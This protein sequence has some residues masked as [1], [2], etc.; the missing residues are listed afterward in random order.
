MQALLEF[1]PLVAFVVAYHLHG[2]YVATGVLMVAMCLL[3]AAAWLRTR[4][5]GSL[6]GT[7]TALVLV[8]GSITL[9]LR[10]E[11]FIQWKPTVFF[12]GFG[13]A[14][15]VSQWLGARPL[16]QRL[17]GAAMPDLQVSR[18]AWLRLNL[19]WVVFYF[20]M[21]ATNLAVARLLDQQTWVNFKVFG[22]T[23]LTFLFVLVQALWLQRQAPV[24]DAPAGRGPNP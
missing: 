20:A 16:V 6:L 7:S 11:R 5:V 1:L 22:I 21:G 3:V 17:I 15:L 4:K 9:I 19:A 8:F 18:E 10:D 14:F 13:L 12:W 2:I 24:T 23:A